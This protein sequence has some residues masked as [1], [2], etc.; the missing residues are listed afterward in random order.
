[1]AVD[2]DVLAAASAGLWSAVIST[3]GTDGDFFCRARI[4]NNQCYTFRRRRLCHGSDVRAAG[5]VW[6][7]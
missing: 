3:L 4:T 1:M 2:T 6:T 7:G 5:R